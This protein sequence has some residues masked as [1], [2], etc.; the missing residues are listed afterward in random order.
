[1]ILR[2]SQVYE[3]AAIN[4]AICY[5]K[6]IIMEFIGL[7]WDT[8]LVQPLV[9]IMVVAYWYLGH[10]FVL[11]TLAATVAVQVITWPLTMKSMESSKKMQ[12]LQA[13]AEWQAMQKKY[14]KEREKLSQ[15]QMRLYRE[16]GVS[17][18]AG[19]LPMLLQFPL[20]I[21]FFNAIN[22]LLA[23]NPEGL[24]GLTR[25][26]YR[27][28][29]FIAD[30]ANQAV[31]LQSQFLW[32]NLGHPDPFYIL[33]LLVAFFTWFSSKTMSASTPSADSQQA[34][35]AQQMQLMMPLMIGF[36]SLSYPAGLA[37]YWI[38]SSGVRMAVQGFTQG[39]SSV[40]P[41][42]FKFELPKFGATQPEEA[43]DSLEQPDLTDGDAPT[44]EKPMTRRQ[45]R[46]ARRS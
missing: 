31:P 17:P 28:V 34:A 7:I 24:L 10:S 26:L 30:I 25:H 6:W 46:Q 37:I 38:I 45:R 20:L 14:G 4:I 41:S 12:A 27:S 15:E 43:T 13:S 1:M 32:L 16:M 11:A 40:L 8:I 33:P 23:A 35:M 36:F 22:L 5:S 18:F 2:E 42:G 44:S 29:P 3:I 39:W 21:A 19:C 9:N